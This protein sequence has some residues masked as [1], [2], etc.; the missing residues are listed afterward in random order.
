MAI[1]SL[2]S[3]A[4]AEVA[5]AS[6]CGNGG[7]AVS[8]A[9]LSTAV[10]AAPGYVITLGQGMGAE[11]GPVDC[12]GRPT[13]TTFYAKAEP[14]IAGKSGTRSFA[15]NSGNTVWEIPGAIAPAEPFAAPARPVQ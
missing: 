14:E 15:T 4:S 10:S 2:K 12:Q 3:I 7:Y 11:A 13:R 5:Y 8:L 1:T 9:V 6:S